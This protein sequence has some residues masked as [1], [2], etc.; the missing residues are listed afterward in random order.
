MI[1]RFDGSFITRF[2]E[3]KTINFYFESYAVSFALNV[4][5]NSPMISCNIC[6]STNEEKDDGKITPNKLS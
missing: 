2:D 4:D 6:S 3:K 5:Y 1:T